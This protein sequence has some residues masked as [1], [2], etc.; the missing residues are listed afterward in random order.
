MTSS[1]K[2]IKDTHLRY[3]KCS[4]HVRYITNRKTTY[5]YDKKNYI[6]QL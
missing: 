4:K 5:I 3:K 6:S 1:K 2:Y